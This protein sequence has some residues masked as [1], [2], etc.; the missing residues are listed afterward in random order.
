M[1][2]PTNNP[3]VS[4]IPLVGPSFLLGEVTNQY[5]PVKLS[6]WSV[7]I[8]GTLLG[9]EAQAGYAAFTADGVTV[10]RG[11]SGYTLANFVG[12]FENQY[13][14]EWDPGSLTGTDTLGNNFTTTVCSIGSIYVYNSTAIAATVS[15][16]LKVVLTIT[17]G[18]TP[19]AI[20][21]GSIIQGAD[22][23]GSSTLDISSVCK[24]RSTQTVV[25]GG[26][27]L[28]VLQS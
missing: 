2:A 21:V 1:V 6:T 3:V 18:T 4:S 20:Q 22:P 16:G 14:N 8:P 7:V 5:Q 9:N 19:A 12:F 11:A 13:F 27:L 10:T 17:T 26:V 28:A 15:S 24:V 23:A 25:G